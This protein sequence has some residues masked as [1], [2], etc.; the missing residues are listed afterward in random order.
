MCFW[1]SRSN[2]IGQT[3]DGKLLRKI[4]IF[5]ISDLGKDFNI[6]R[7][8]W[9]R[10]ARQRCL[11]SSNDAPWRSGPSWLRFHKDLK[12]EEHPNGYCYVQVG[13]WTTSFEEATKVANVL[14]MQWTGFL[15]KLFQT[16]LS[17]SRTHLHIAV[18]HIT[19]NNDCIIGCRAL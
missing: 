16:L 3:F 4:R 2:F 8:L 6:L 1:D 14:L 15:L 12:R 5:G 10:E 11:S 18:M 17:C 19:A 7:K 9:P 13:T